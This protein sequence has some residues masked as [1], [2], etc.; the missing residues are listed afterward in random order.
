MVTIKGYKVKE[1]ENSKEFISLELEGD[2]AFIQSQNTGRFYATTKKSYMNSYAIDEVTAKA[3][4]GT[5]MP[6]SIERIPCDP[7]EYTIKDTGEVVSLSYSHQYVP[8]GVEKAE[9]VGTQKTFA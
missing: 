3:L 2:L 4:V 1:G 6:G 7:Y 9:V 5:K 8:D